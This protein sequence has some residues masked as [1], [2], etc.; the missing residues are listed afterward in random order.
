MKLE[1]RLREIKLQLSILTTLS[2]STQ[3]AHF[4]SRHLC[5]ITNPLCS[6]FKRLKGSKFSI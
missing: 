1:I 4:G 3:C 2:V 5:A 6:L